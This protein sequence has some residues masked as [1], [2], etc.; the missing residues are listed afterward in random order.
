MARFEMENLELEEKVISV[1]RVAKV[2]KGG[3]RF[4][5]TALVAV[6]DKNGRVGVGHGKAPEV[7]DAIRKGTEAARKNM[8]SVNLLKGTIPHR[9]DGEFGATRVVMRP[10]SPGTGVIAG[11]AV[12][13]VLE[14]VGIQDILAKTLGSRNPHNMV[15]ATLNGLAAL[16]TREQE[17]KA[18]Q[19]E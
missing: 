4:S 9:I 17:V 3:R 11:G 10:A 15:K 2:V 14:S 19:A 12:R 7:S 8:T 5:F 6:G 18:R 13:A 16:Q 1:K